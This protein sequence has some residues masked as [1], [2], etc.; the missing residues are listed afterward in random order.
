MFNGAHTVVYS[1]DAE[2]DRQFLADILGFDHVDAGGGWLIFALAPGEIA[3]HPHDTST[4]HELYLMCDDI[5]AARAQ[6]MEHGVICAE[7]V[8]EGWGLLSSFKLPGGAQIG[9]YEPRHARAT[10]A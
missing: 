3:V 9:F 1:A 6:L 7:V 5:K 10:K 8:D 4:A 2:K